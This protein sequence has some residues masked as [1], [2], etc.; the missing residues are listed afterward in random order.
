M[1]R[2]AHGLVK[3]SKKFKYYHATFFF[4]ET[5]EGLYYI[6]ISCDVKFSEDQTDYFTN[7]EDKCIHSVEMRDPLI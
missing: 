4:C 3:N 1:H 5:P 7:S 6:C 2:A